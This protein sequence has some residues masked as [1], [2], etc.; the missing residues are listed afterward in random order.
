MAETADYTYGC[1]E[2]FQT[3]FG[4]HLLSLSSTSVRMLCSYHDSKVRSD[5]GISARYDMTQRELTDDATIVNLEKEL[6][7][8]KILA[9]FG[10]AEYADRVISF[11]VAPVGSTH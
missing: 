11:L 1:D 5:I 3:Q 8:Q 9:T 4:R 10:S 6:A 7:R 2:R